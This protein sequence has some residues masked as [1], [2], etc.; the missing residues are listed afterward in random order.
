MV[1]GFALYLPGGKAER[2]RGKGYTK[3][4]LKA[5]SNIVAVNRRKGTLFLFRPRAPAARGASTAQL[6]LF[7][8]EHGDDAVANGRQLVSSQHEEVLCH[9]PYLQ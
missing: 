8:Q 9:P 3:N 4:A 2:T 5:L 1:R 7:R 6:F